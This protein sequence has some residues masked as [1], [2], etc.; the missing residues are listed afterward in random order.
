[1][2]APQYLSSQFVRRMF[3]RSN[4]PTGVVLDSVENQWYGTYIKFRFPNFGSLEIRMPQSLRTDLYSPS[5][6]EAFVSW[7]RLVWSRFQQPTLVGW[8]DPAQRLPEMNRYVPVAT[9]FGSSPKFAAYSRKFERWVDE[10][11]DE[12]QGVTQWFDL[13]N[14]ES[15]T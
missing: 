5:G 1:M 4:P 9:Q 13:P 12:I 3:P 15:R 11:T 8:V 2:P 10:D 14:P 7:L 6:E